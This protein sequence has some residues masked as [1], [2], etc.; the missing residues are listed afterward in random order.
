MKLHPEKGLTVF[1]GGGK[2]SVE[3]DYFSES[4]GQIGNTPGSAEHFYC[5][6]NFAFKILIIVLF[7][8]TVKILN[9]IAVLD[10]QLA[11]TITPYFS[12]AVFELTMARFESSS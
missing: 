11:C 4:I 5:N 9:L 6:L 10:I 1:E 2:L 12:W 3:H 7:A 8:W